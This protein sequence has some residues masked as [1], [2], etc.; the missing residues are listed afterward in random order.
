M[1]DKKMIII[2]SVAAVAIIVGLISV[3]QA[4]KAKKNQN[5]VV[6]NV[7]VVKNDKWQ[8]EISN[9]TESQAIGAVTKEIEH[10]VNSAII[11]SSFS[12]PN[13]SIVY[14]ITVTNKGNLDA[15][16]KDLTGIELA[17]SNSLVQ[18]EVLDSPKDVLKPNQSQIIKIKA[19]RIPSENYASIMIG[20][21][22]VLGVNYIQK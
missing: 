12:Y 19:T 6:K 18:Y 20:K 11:T 2:L 5:K 14:D 15:I 7:S 17:N 10:S 3:T 16:L 4:M 9:I 8:V 1:K 13:A 21:T 22:L